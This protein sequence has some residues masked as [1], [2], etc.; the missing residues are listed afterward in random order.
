MTLKEI[1]SSIQ[2]IEK[3]SWDDEAAHSNEDAL[4]E[5]FIEYVA[6]LKDLPSLSKKAKLVLSTGDIEF[7]RW[8]A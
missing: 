6:S 3:S 4:R 5:R 7:S 1:K 8:C 2:D